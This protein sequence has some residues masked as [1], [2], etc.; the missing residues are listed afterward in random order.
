MKK[1]NILRQLLKFHD[2]YLFMEAEK[3]DE[4]IYVEALK[5]LSTNHLVIYHSRLSLLSNSGS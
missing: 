1:F 4:I 5:Y 2:K 3:I